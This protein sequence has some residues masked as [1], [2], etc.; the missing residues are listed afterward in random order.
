M[1]NHY[2]DIVKDLADKVIEYDGIYDDEKYFQAIDDSL[3][4]EDEAYIVANAIEKGII[5][6][7]YDVNWD[8]VNDMLFS[9]IMEEIRKIK[10]AKDGKN[11]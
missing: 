6:W 1:S 2:Y 9:D 4:K 3:K 11:Y 10:G 5:S 8:A 7:G